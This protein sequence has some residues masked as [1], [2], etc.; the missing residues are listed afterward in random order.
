MRPRYFTKGGSLIYNGVAFY[1]ERKVWEFSR[2]INANA[3]LYEGLFDELDENYFGRA[4][5]R[6]GASRVPNEIF[7]HPQWS[8]ARLN[9]R[10][11]AE[12]GFGCG[13]PDIGTNTV[14]Q[15]VNWEKVK[16]ELSGTRAPSVI[17]G[18]AWFGNVRFSYSLPF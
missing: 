15:A 4:L 1:P 14:P 13:H 10:L 7:T 8:G 3:S 2:S 18:E 16:E 6:S 5:H 12:A 17:K 11:S 9:Q